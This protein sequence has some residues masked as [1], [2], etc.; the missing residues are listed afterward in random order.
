MAAGA[1]LT[2]IA[3]TDLGLGDDLS[4]QV[5]SESEDE[6]KKRLAQQSLMQKMS[7][8]G[9]AASLLGSPTGLPGG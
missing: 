1:G 6:R 8:G 5:K 3:S 7:P 9:A 4:S 2:G